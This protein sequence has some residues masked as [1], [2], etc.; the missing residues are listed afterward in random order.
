MA[1][2]RQATKIIPAS[3][4]P[5]AT[6]WV[7]GSR[8][9][10]IRALVLAALSRGPECRLVKALRCEDSDLMMAA[11]SHAGLEVAIVE[12]YRPL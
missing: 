8:A 4:P 11:A 3:R 2:S 9:S 7:P 10:P 12:I 5:V 6:V 1:L